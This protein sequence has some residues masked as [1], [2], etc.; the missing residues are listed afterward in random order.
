M[1]MAA[2]AKVR[3]IYET[4]SQNFIWLYNQAR[5]WDLRINTH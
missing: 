2:P 4:F 3:P 5:T 1:Q